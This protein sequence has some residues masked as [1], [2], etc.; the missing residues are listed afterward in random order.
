MNNQPILSL[1]NV[2]VTANKKTLLNPVSF[3]VA[4]KTI[5]SLMGPSGV[6]KSTLL[7]CIN[8]L[9]DLQPELKVTGEIWY[10]NQ[11]IL[12]PK[13]AA[14]SVRKEIGMVFQAPVIFPGSIEK[15]VLFGVRRMMP[16][17]KKEFKEIL[18]MSLKEAALWD[19]VKDRLKERASVLSVGQKQRLSMARVLAMRP[20]IIL[21]DEPTSALDP[22]STE[23][24][25]QLFVSLKKNHTLVLVTH[26]RSQTDAICDSCVEFLWENGSGRIQEIK[27]ICATEC[28]SSP[29]E[30]LIK[31]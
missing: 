2:A 25:Q 18:E 12:S 1:K 11:N 9:T 15:N 6:G 23:L 27:T 10:K 5:H 16:E 29:E 4:P 30:D 7:K 24:I 28:N 3:D 13:T 14:E 21:L 31:T 26:D 20:A 22:R 8:R 17:K 19:E